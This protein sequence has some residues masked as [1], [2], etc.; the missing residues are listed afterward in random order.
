MISVVSLANRQVVISSPSFVSARVGTRPW[1]EGAHA[2]SVEFHTCRSSFNM[3][4]MEGKHLDPPEEDPRRSELEV[5]S[6]Q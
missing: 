5:V 1:Y 2:I 4:V 6:L 3:V